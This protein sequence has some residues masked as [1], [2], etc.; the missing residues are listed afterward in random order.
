VDLARKWC[1]TELLT[2]FC[3]NN[4]LQPAVYHV[5]SNVDYTYHFGMC[6]FSTIDHFL[7]T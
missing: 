4:G 1:Q 7:I 6:R 5:S 3:N 2:S